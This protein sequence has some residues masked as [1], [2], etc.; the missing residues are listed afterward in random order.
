MNFVDLNREEVVRTTFEAENNLDFR[1]G[2]RPLKGT[3]IARV[4]E[5]HYELRLF[6]QDT[7]MATQLKQHA[8]HF[9]G[10]RGKRYGFISNERF[11]NTIGA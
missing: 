7:S 5:S 4:G 6:H 1:L 10:N 11:R 3:G 8:V 9:V 2:T